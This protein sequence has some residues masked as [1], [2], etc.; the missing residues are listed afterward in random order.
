VQK[1]YT[2]VRKAKARLAEIGQRLYGERR[3][4]KGNLMIYVVAT[5]EIAPGKR[6]QWLELFV[7]LIPKVLAEDGCIEYGPAI[8]IESGIGKQIPMRENVV[9]VLE[10]WESL[11][12]LKAHTLAPH[13][14]EY[15]EIVKGLVRSLE[16][17]VLIP[18]RT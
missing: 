15:K 6:D 4:Q 5:V 3:L 17:Q 10:K 7:E 18:A 1:W 13:M 9:T 2:L 16:L 11:D 12:A 14:A 8:D